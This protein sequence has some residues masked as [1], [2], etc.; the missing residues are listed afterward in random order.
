M[1]ACAPSYLYSIALGIL[2]SVIASVIFLLTIYRFKPT[3]KISPHI[4]RSTDSAGKFF[5]FKVINDSPRPVVDVRVDVALTSRASV[6]DGTVHW[7]K[8]IPIVKDYAFHLGPKS[9]DDHEAKYAFRFVTECDLDELWKGDAETIRFRVI[10]TDALTGFRK[11][12]FMEF[13]L[14]RTCIKDGMHEWGPGLEVK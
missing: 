11:C 3:I 4:A 14:P 7:T 6:P 8:Q 5:S 10:A 1:D 12:E 13:R 9:A 2:S